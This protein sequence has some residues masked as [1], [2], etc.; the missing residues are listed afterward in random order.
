MSEKLKPCPFCGEPGVMSH[1]D[2]VVCFGCKA[3]GPID[4]PGGAKWN[5]R[6]PLTVADCLQVPEVRYAI[7][8]LREIRAAPERNKPG[9]YPSF[10]RVHH[11][12]EC[13]CEVCL[14]LRKID[15]AMEKEKA[16]E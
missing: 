8:L 12:D 16:N 4:D 1:F 6:A 9:W 7:Q 5:R 10:L 13:N 15:S 2:C 14:V 3:D 11:E